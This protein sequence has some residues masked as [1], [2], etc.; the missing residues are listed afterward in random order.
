MA[1]VLIHSTACYTDASEQEGAL[2]G[3]AQSYSQLKPGTY[4]GTVEA[5]DLGRVS[6]WRERINL[7]VEERTAPPAGRVTFVTAANGGSPY[8]LNAGSLPASSVA[9]LEGERELD[10]STDGA[11]DFL[12]VSIDDA[13][14]GGQGR[15]LPSL[16]PAPAAEAFDFC[17]LWLLSLLSTVGAAEAGLVEMAAVLPGA[18]VDRLKFVHGKIFEAPPRR[19]RTPADLALFRR[20][21]EIAS[22]DAI[23]NL[24]VDDLAARLGVSSQ[25]LRDAFVRVLG[26][27]PGNW[28][29]THRLDGARRDL[30]RAEDTGETVSSIAARWGFWHFGRFSRTYAA[31]YGEPPSQ[32]M[33]R[34]R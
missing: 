17:A 15:P 32:T 28:L 7:A 25:T 22:E 27:G 3:W 10:V 8:R 1:D 21:R 31:F 34:R 16:C 26:I 18:V 29:R 12:I 19:E 20:A 11:S 5:L 2:R 24:S 14:L 4:A 33:R 9:V 13:E 30:L 6:V 23:D